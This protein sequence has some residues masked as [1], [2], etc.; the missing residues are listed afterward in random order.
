MMENTKRLSVP[1][2]HPGDQDKSN[3]KITSVIQFL[4]DAE[5][6][7]SP[8]A[9]TT[10]AS[11]ASVSSVTSFAST[12]SP[13]QP[14][15]HGGSKKR[16]FFPRE[17]QLRQQLITAASEGRGNIDSKPA[18]ISITPSSSEFSSARS[19]TIEDLPVPTR[20]IP[21]R[22]RLGTTDSFS[23]KDSIELMAMINAIEHEDEDSCKEIF[24][25]PVVIEK[26]NRT[27]IIQS[28]NEKRSIGRIHSIENERPVEYLKH[29]LTKL[30][31]RWDSLKITSNNVP[32]T[33]QDDKN[34]S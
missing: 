27:P 18:L 30:S 32:A 26:Q 22:R 11:I 15:Q 12:S 1:D 25:R 19:F 24:H 31:K 33:D 13:T 23:S 7:V 10:S 17:L 4:D 28:I 16:R 20:V 6:K 5:D 29:K 21:S 34:K 9:S 3:L 2:Q 14:L 8:L